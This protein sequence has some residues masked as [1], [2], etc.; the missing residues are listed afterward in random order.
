VHRRSGG[1]HRKMI[2]EQGRPPQ[3]SED[4]ILAGDE[5]MVAGS[6]DRAPGGPPGITVDWLRIPLAHCDSQHR[7]SRGDDHRF[8]SS[9]PPLSNNFHRA[10]LTSII[11]RRASAFGALLLEYV[12]L[13]AS[14]TNPLVFCLATT[15][16]RSRFI[17]G[18]MEL[19]CRRLPD[20]FTECAG[21]SRRRSL[22]RGLQR[23]H[24]RSLPP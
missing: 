20:L 15:P 17:L 16:G 18:E 8:P 22:H 1:H 23:S 6:L 4:W 9:D 3:A 11:L 7:R 24:H 10:S 12:L 14:S 19:A 2:S 13:V 21:Q 5:R